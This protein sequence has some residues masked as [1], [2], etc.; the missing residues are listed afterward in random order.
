M[1]PI[2]N[3]IAVIGMGYVGL[4]LSLEFAKKDHVIGFDIDNIRIKSLKKGIDLTEE[5]KKK[6]ILKSKK[7]KFS[8]DL[9]DLS[10]CNIYIVTVPTPVDSK[11]KPNLKPLLNATEMISK[12]LTKNNIVIYESTVFPGATEELCGPII[13]RNS[14]LKI[15]LDIFLGY[16]PERIN[17]GDKNKK[18]TDIIKIVSGSNSKTLKRVSKLYSRIIKAGVFEVE[19]IKIA[20]AAK[21]I[22]NTQR[23]LNI[24]FINELSLIFKKLNLSTEKILQAAETKW[25]FISFRPGL[26]GGHCIG[27]DPYYLTYKSKKIGYKPKIILGG[28]NLNDQMSLKVYEDVNRIILKNNNTYKN[29]KI[30]IMGLTFKENCPDTRNSKVLDLFNHFKRKK[31]DISSFDPY[32]KNWSLEF[33]EKFNV[34]NQFKNK[35]FDVVII[36]VK[37]FKF[38][39]MKKQI[40]ILLNKNGFIYDLKYL[41]PENPK[42]YRL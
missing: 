10:D 31:F 11:N 39:K 2:I 18:L 16:S 4:P 6:E 9:E 27:V 19:S 7:I 8:S 29:K 23:D 35:K 28:R 13:E 41:F 21:V 24:A 34:I 40:K 37:H 12:V 14:G 15:N 5:V 22:E 38:I 42:I 17:P 20:E 1:K 30:L 32:S 25:N 33:K 3:K 36:A 26:V